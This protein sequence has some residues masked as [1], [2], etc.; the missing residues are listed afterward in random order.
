M[1]KSGDWSYVSF[2]HQNQQQQGLTPV[3]GAPIAN[4][5][6][7]PFHNGFSGSGGGPASMQQQ[8]QQHERMILSPQPTSLLES[9]VLASIIQNEKTS[10]SAHGT[11][12]R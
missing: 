6:S 12:T 9:K 2:P 1:R 7:S 3:N 11:P 8:G 4:N 5:G 10:K